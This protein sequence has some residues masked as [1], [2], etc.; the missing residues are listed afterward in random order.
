MARSLTPDS[1]QT[2]AVSNGNGYLLQGHKLLGHIPREDDFYVVFARMEEGV[3]AFLI[4]AETDGVTLNGKP[5][6]TLENCSL[7]QDAVLGEIGGAF[8]LGVDYI[9]HQAV[10]IGAR[11]VGMA[12]RLLDMSAQYAKDWVSMGQPLALR[13]AVMR[14][15][16]EVAA[17]THAARYMVYHAACHQALMVRLFTGEMIRKAI[18]KTIMVHGGT[19][20][21]EQSPAIRMYRNLVPDESLEVGLENSRMAVAEHYLQLQTLMAAD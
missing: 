19:S 21:L 17:E 4:D 5:E 15:V 11:Y 2:T 3:T 10:K 9:P 16:A 20:Y 7:S 6:I 13:P 14:M 8:Q 12:Q 1:W 18:D